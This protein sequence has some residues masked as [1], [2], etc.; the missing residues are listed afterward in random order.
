MR[1]V[2]NVSAYLNKTGQENDTVV[3]INRGMV[4]LIVVMVHIIII[5]SRALS[6][7]V[8]RG[9]AFNTSTLNVFRFSKLCSGYGS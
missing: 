8:D 4:Q 9:T 2:V 3:H 5:A 7:W 1:Y 6:I